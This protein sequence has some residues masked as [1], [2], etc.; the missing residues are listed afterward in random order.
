[1]DGLKTELDGRRRAGLLRELRPIQRRLHGRIV[2]DGR[3]YLDCSSNDYLGLAG[4]HRLIAAAKE[5]LDKFG[6]GAGASR[7]MTGSLALHHELEEKTARFKGKPAALVF[8]SGYQANVGIFAALAGRND[9]VFCDR[10]GH[11][12]LIDGALLA[13]CKLIRFRHNDTAH[14]SELLAGE[15]RKYDRAWIVTESVFSMDG[16]RAPLRELVALKEEHNCRLF[17]DEAHATGLFGADGAGAVSEEGVTG[18]VD[19]IMGTFSK[20]LGSFG[21][22]VA[23]SRELVDYLVNACRSFIYTTALP[24]AVIAASN[25]AIDVV[26]AEPER[27]RIVLES[28][29]SFRRLLAQCS[30]LV[31]GESQIVPLV[32]GDNERALR[33]A[34]QLREAGFWVNAIR[35]PTVPNGE[36]R[37]RF[38]ITWHHAPRELGSL[39]DALLH[40][41]V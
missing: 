41:R 5:A 18:E 26:A 9:V 28:A 21:A 17:V 13:G 16:D 12:S 19:V 38:S 25:A 3:E 4:H 15:R 7:L 2:I 20:A 36:A 8:N 39:M 10:L 32:A 27:R 34:A 35:P 6:A 40:V 11:A 30:F 1:M 31:R 23:S 37:L 22:Y 29:A 14:L 33:M 24:P